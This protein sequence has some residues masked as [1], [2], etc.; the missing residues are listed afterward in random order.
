[1]THIQF[2]TKAAWAN[3]LLFSGALTLGGLLFIMSPKHSISEGEKRQLKLMP[4]FSWS[5]VASGQYLRQLDDYIA[6]NFIWRYTLTELSGEVRAMR[7]WNH[8]DMQVFSSVQKK[9]QAMAL[10][11]VAKPTASDSSQAESVSSP[12]LALKVSAQEGSPVVAVGVKLSEINET[13]SGNVTIVESSQAAIEVAVP[14]TQLAEANVTVPVM[15]AVEAKPS[16]PT[17]QPIEAKV[18]VLA[19]QPPPVAAPAPAP[20][21]APAQAATQAPTPAPA[22][23]PVQ[24][25]TSVSQ[26]G[27]TAS[28]VQ[29]ASAS[30]DLYENVES[31]IIYR[32]RALQMFG[33]APQMTQ[34]LAKAINRYREELPPEI[35]IF[36]MAVPI[37]SD[38]YLP[39]KVNNGVMR[40]KLAIDHIHTLLD[41]GVKF[42]SAYDRLAEHTDEYIQ[43]NTDHHWTGLGGYYAYTA[44]AEAAGFK[45]LPLNK[46][47]KGEI[48]N[49]LGTLYQ[50]TMAP[51]L[52]N[53]IDTV[54]YFKVPVN[55]EATYYP[56][57]SNTPV[58]LPLYAEY[59]R[60]GNAYGVFLGGDF[61][62][63]RV[64]SDVKNGKKIAVIK[65]SYGNAFVP[66]LAAHYEEV[67]ILDYRYF[68]GNIKTL[69][70]DNG[71][72]NLLFAHNTFVVMGSYTAQRA[73]GFLTAAPNA[74]PKIVNK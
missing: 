17:T 42:V 57:N 44:F 74:T 25:P 73:I 16:A 48:P 67:F 31:I 43:F 50:R 22:A 68:V 58:P 21:A 19:V 53:K 55:T 34:S 72:Q 20:T 1:M 66:Y 60:G 10:A 29:A 8:D 56:A 3:I 65:D 7:G 12:V 9:P 13:A 35:N 5:S 4:T 26:L 11:S 46:L 24:K 45:P 47:V 51:A 33:G 71:I 70:E 14:T 23:L 2:S 32:G 6:D 38:F 39:R 40:E 63:M 30:E 41:P 62:L 28:S 59:A 64:V 18:S 52:R 37:G 36:F 69:L 61:P 54:E 49:F 15:Q 27:T